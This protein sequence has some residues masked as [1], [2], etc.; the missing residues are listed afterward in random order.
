MKKLVFVITMFFALLL[1]SDTI[2]A[3]ADTEYVTALK[4][5]NSGKY[6]GAV[7]HLK[8][9]VKKNPDPAAYYLMGYALYKLKRF[10][11]AT[12]YFNEAY[13]I[14]PNFSLE[15]AG[16]IQ[17]LPEEKV[18]EITKPSGEQVPPKQKPPVPE[19]KVVKPEVKVPVPVKQPSK[20]IQPRKPEAPK[21]T[22]KKKAPLPEP[23]KAEPQKKIEPPAGIPSLP[24]PKKGMPEA[25]PILA[26]PMLMGGLFAGFAMIFLAIYIA[27]YVYGCLCLFLIAKKLNVPAP[28][29][30]WIPFVQVW[31]LVTSA[32]KPWWWILLLLIPVLNLIVLIY[33][34]VCITEK[35]GR[36]KW[37]GLLIL[38]PI[39]N[40]VFIGI[41]AFS[42]TEGVGGGT[43]PMD[44]T[45]TLEKPLPSE[46]EPPEEEFP[47]GTTSMD[48][49]ATLKNPLPSEEKPTEEEL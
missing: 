29:T 49:T 22:P 7:E 34:W 41:L 31:T 21:V 10:D 26:I 45:V 15:K 24:K 27:L 47:G 33:L 38:A 1:V 32:G 42:K 43:M 44:E 17:K 28:W 46:E 23:K 13:L 19:S 40:L 48:E 6:K 30:A 3:Q 9:Y 8:D 12:E 18:K 2:L 11:E 35:L 4:Y 5:Y 36:N 39:V 20:E 14:D 37:L 25:F 16:L